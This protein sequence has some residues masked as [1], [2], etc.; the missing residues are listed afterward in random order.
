MTNEELI[1][2]HLNDINSDFQYDGFN[3][4]TFQQWKREGKS[5]MKGQKAT[6]TVPL[7]TMKLEDEKDEN[8]KIIKDESG[9]PKKEKKFYKKNASLFTADQV[10]EI[11][12]KPSRKKATK[13]A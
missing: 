7:W 12:K 5:V 13:A 3:L 4:K 8:G 1:T 6:F 10:E 2:Q 9:K 11:K